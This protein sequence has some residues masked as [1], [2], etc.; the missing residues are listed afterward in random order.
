MGWEGGGV[1]VERRMDV[2]KKTNETR[3]FWRAHFGRKIKNP[4]KSV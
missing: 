3:H 1:V 2:V 4:H